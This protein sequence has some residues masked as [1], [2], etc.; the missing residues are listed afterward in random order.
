MSN[1]I[2]K[3]IYLIL[4]YSLKRKLN[5]IGFQYNKKKKKKPSKSRS[6]LGKKGIGVLGGFL[7]FFGALYFILISV[8]LIY[9]F[10]YQLNSLD[11]IHRVLQNNKLPSNYSSSSLTRYDTL[12]NEKFDEYDLMM[13]EKEKTQVWN[14]TKEEFSAVIELQ[15]YQAAPAFGVNIDD[16]FKQYYQTRIIP[17]ETLPEKSMAA[18]GN[19]QTICL[20]YLICGS[21]AL[22]SLFTALSFSVKDLGVTDK[23]YEW[24]ASNALPIQSL[25]LFRV[26][27]NA[28]SNL[29]NWLVILPVL[30]HIYLIFKGPWFLPIAILVWLIWSF[31]IGAIQVLIELYFQHYAGLQKAKLFQSIC[32]IL[33]TGVMLLGSLANASLEIKE[34]AYQIFSPYFNVFSWVPF[35]HLPFLR[36]E[37]PFAFISI[38]ILVKLLVL[39]LYLVYIFSKA[40]TKDGLITN[41]TGYLGKRSQNTSKTILIKGSKL[42]TVISFEKLMLFRNKQ[43]FI[44]ILI[45]PCILGTYYYYAFSFKAKTL[46]DPINI[47]ITAFVVG[48]YIFLF[49]TF[50]LVQ[51]EGKGLWLIFTLPIDVSEYFFRKIWLWAAFS[52]LFFVL[53]YLIYF[54]MGGSFSAIFFINF[55][56]VLFGIAIYAYISTSIGIISYDPLTTNEAQHNNQAFTFL[57]MYL[58]GFYISAIFNENILSKFYIIILAFTIALG[59]KTK[60]TSTLKYYFDK[61][62]VSNKLT[63][64]ES[65]LLIFFYIS[66]LI[67]VQTISFL[68]T[69]EQNIF[70]S[71]LISTGIMLVILFYCSRIFPDIKLIGKELLFFYRQRL[72]SLQLFLYVCVTIAF[73]LGYLVILN[74]WNLFSINDQKLETFQM[75]YVLFAIFVAPIVEE[76]LFRRILF[77]TLKSYYS[78]T[79]ANL[80]SSLLFA[81][82]HPPASFLP[83]FLLGSLSASLYHQKNQII[84]PILLHI[85]YNSGVII[86]QINFF[87]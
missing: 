45:L 26:I 38:I 28:F 17:L 74:R 11:Q 70:I 1:N 81:M 10:I 57:Y 12:F 80:F 31:L 52:Y 78:I 48:T 22:F 39:S 6:A 40:L 51:R 84:Q 76:I 27:E 53:I 79:L 49:T 77:K 41:A 66:I 8:G 73:A 67:T 43:I 20:L 55:F 33:A 54:I 64:F 34:M 75:Q 68:V 42:N 50:T 9:F 60:V 5:R 3:I 44:T 63:V 85:F 47:N 71:G 59:L 7:Y 25:L 32:H 16:K 72:H 21:L 46:I 62:I 58:C 14:S 87:N 23:Y 24:L 29:V 13:N 18:L 37:D 19:S 30:I 4:K 82:A 86:L 69:K 35:F 2:L 65:I 61:S 56:V 83:V 36:A 15:F